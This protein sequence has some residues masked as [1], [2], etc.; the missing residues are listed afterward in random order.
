LIALNSLVVILVI[1]GDYERA[2][3][4]GTQQLELAIELGAWAAESSAYVNLAWAATA[5]GN[6]QAAEELATKGIAAQRKTRHLDAVGEGLVWL[7]YAKLGLG[8][9]VEAENAFRESLEI[10]R[11]LGQEALQVESMAGL[12]KALLMGGDL[13]GAREYGEK[14]REYILRDENLSGT[15]E[16]LKIYWICYQILKAVGD[17]RKNDFL[18]DAVENLQKRAKKITDKDAQKR[19]L[20]NVPWHREILVEWERI[21]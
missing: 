15:W 1:L 7:G 10:R 16:S 8:Q 5:E 21:L 3:E 11:G 2:K 13:D 19:Y 6:W 14:I 12:G 9:Q 17:S 4:Y 18:K 20:N